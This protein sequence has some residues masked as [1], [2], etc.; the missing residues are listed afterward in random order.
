[1]NPFSLP[2][3]QIALAASLLAGLSLA[4]IGLFILVKRIS[5]SGLAVSQLAALGTVVGTVLGLHYGDIWIALAFVGMGIYL[6]SRISKNSGVPQEL[7]VASLYILGAGLAVLILSKAPQG[8][9]DTLSVFFGNLLALGVAEIWEA[10]FIFILTVLILW[11]WFYRWIWIAFDPTSVEVAKFKVDLWNFLFYALFALSMTVSIH[12]FGVLLAFSYLLLPAGIGLLCIRKFKYLFIFI[13]LL[14]ALTT[15]LGF[16]FSF[17]LDLPTGPFL[18][19]LFAATLLVCGIY[20]T[21][22]SS[23]KRPMR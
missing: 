6:L 12:I 13:P 2:F 18:A 10:F 3:M 17:R 15:L 5:F 22:K 20:R 16:Y 14:T 8:E 21:P 9:A 4:W 1:M 7:F 19:S 23:V 11:G